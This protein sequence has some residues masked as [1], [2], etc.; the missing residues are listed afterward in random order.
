MTDNLTSKLQKSIDLMVSTTIHLEWFSK[1]PVDNR[2]KMDYALRQYQNL[3]T[4]LS[5]EGS[6]KCALKFS[7]KEK[8]FG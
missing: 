2:K 3:L 4:Y 1:Q 5:N 7:E 6:K 8:R